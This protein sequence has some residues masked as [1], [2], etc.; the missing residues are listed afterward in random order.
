[1]ECTL[2]TSIHVIRKSGGT[3]YAPLVLQDRRVAEG[4]PEP[5]PERLPTLNSCWERSTT[6]DSANKDR[7]ATMTDT[8]VGVD[9]SRAWIDTFCPLTNQHQRLT[10]DPVI[11]DTFAAG[12]SSKGVVVVLEATGGCERALLHALTIHKVGYARV[13][14]RQAR[15]FA[16]ATGR[17]A[18]TDAVDARMLADMGAKFALKAD[19]PIDPQRARLADLVARREALIGYIT[20]EKQ[21]LG[22]TVDLFIKDDIA[23]TLTFLKTRL[24]ALTKEI[25]AHIKSA[26]QLAKLD[27]ALQSAPGIG[28]VVAATLVAGLP[29]IG[30]TNR[31]AL[32][33]LAGLAPHACDSG[34][35]RGSR[36]I[37]GGRAQIRR[38]LYL[39]AFIASSRD[40][41][42]KEFRAKLS[43]QQ[44]P[45]KAIIIAVARKLLTHLNAMIRSGQPW[46][47]Q[48]NAELTPA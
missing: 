43:N 8:Y 33:S 22:T 2:V 40:P 1:M 24:A 31:R 12:L 5:F 19:D 23:T 7:S 21:R 6:T 46:S 17:L 29:E 41:V 30:T 26:T 42:L 32:A 36:H 27:A 10:M 37:W 15:E 13:N 39:A 11:L 28:P 45:F 38:A 35:R 48:I 14:P 47:N 16:R 44:R 18:K 25:A 9:V 20:K 34:I 4:P 3:L